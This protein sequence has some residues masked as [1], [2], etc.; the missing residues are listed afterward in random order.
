MV[1]TLD[2]YKRSFGARVYKH[3]VIRTFIDMMD[4]VLDGVDGLV[5][6]S[7]VIRPLLYL[8]ATT[9]GLVNVKV[10]TKVKIRRRCN[11]HS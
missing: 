7:S 4:R 9:A 3:R 6:E 11:L 2:I 8:Q 10:N 1:T 5:T